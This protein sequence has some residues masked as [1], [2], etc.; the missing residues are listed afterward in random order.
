MAVRPRT[1]LA[2]AALLL[3]A[4]A[5][6]GHAEL[7]LTFS[8][9]LL[10]AAAP[11][12]GRFPG[13]TLIVARRAVAAARRRPVHRTWPADRAAALTS[14]LERSPRTLRGPPAAA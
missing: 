9:W 12:L 3:L 4:L 8:P 2:L 14:L 13:E 1:R 7:A 10:I 11:L 6:A 5:A